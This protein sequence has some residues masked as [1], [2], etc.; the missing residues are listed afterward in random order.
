[1]VHRRKAFTLIEVLVVIA[2]IGVLV[3]ILLPAVQ[4]VREA[5]NRV[6]CQNNLKQ[7]GVAMHNYHADYLGFP[8]GTVNYV[9]RPQGAPRLTY[10]IF[11]YPYLDQSNVYRQF[12]QRPTEGTPDGYADGGV[13]AWCS[14]SN[15]LGPPYPPITATIVPGLLCPS[16]GVGDRITSH[17]DDQGTLF[18]T[19]NMSNY[20]GFFGN[21]NYGSYFP[22]T[23]PG[24]PPNKKAVFGINYGARLTDI[25]DGTSNT[26]AFGEYLRGLS[27]ENKD[28]HRGNLWNDSPGYSQLY[29]QF[30]PNSSNPDLFFPDFHCYNRPD[31]NLPCA[32]STEDLTVAASRSRHPG[33][34]NVLMADGSVRFIQESINLATWQAL[35]TIQAGEVLGDF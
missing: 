17:I 18:G 31:L 2:I 9:F 14:N 8:H 10:M 30:A 20:L 19:W 25:T 15:C 3:G 28:D 35:G 21:R 13:I 29:T 5:A 24:T 1:M 33:G 6:S 32:G 23:F 27:Q 12:N 4:K 16:D 7:L 11:L 26:M 22:A 34:V